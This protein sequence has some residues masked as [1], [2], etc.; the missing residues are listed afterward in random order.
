MSYYVKPISVF[1]N[2][3]L[4]KTKVL[5]NLGLKSFVIQFLLYLYKIDMFEEIQ[6]F[7]FIYSLYSLDTI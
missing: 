7:D 1:L 5:L 4:T 3:D 2:F 6:M